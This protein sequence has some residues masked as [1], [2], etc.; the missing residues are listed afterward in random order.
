MLT[1]KTAFS[2]RC[3]VMHTPRVP[4]LFQQ[5]VSPDPPAHRLELIPTQ[6]ISGSARVHSRVLYI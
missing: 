5:G 6:A 1:G 3:E 4:G 2:M